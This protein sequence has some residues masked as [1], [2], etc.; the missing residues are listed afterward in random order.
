MFDEMKIEPFL[1]II[2]VFIKVN[3]FLFWLNLNKF[4]VLWLPVNTKRKLYIKSENR[5]KLSNPG[6]AVTEIIV[7]IY[8]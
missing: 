3:G 5:N 8:K 6:M 4:H 1:V 2:L 7:S